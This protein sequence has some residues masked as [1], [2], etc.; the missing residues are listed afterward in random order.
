MA[1]IEVFQF[2]MCFDALN[3][4]GDDGKVTVVKGKKFLISESHQTPSMF[5]SPLER[6][7]P[8]GL[9]RGREFP[10]S[11]KILEQ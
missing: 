8:V 10:F 5:S 1:K 2:K 4:Q 9:K 6:E 3:S 11:R 7:S